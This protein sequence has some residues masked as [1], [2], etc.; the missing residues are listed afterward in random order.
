LTAVTIARRRDVE[1]AGGAI[2]SY[3]RR[4]VG[5]P[6]PQIEVA[7]AAQDGP[8]REE[9]L[10]FWRDRVGFSGEAAERRLG[11]VVC[12]LRDEGRVAGVSSVYAANVEVLAGWRFWI[13]RCLLAEGLDDSLSGLISATFNAL[14]GVH[15]TD[16]G[17]PVGLCVLLDPAQRRHVSPAAEWSDPRMIS[18]GYLPDGRQ[19]RIAYF[20]NEVSSMH[21][22]EPA[23]GWLP[24]GY[25]ME[26]FG[27]ESSVRREDVIALWTSEAGLSRA[28]ADRRL[29]E[30]LL[31]AVAPDGSLA[32]IS[33]AY[34][35]FNAQLGAD[36]WYYRTFVAAAHRKANLAVALIVASR[37]HIVERF[38]SGQDRRGL[39]LIFELENEGLK[40][41]FPK[42]IWYESDFL[43][44]GHNPRGAHVRV[45]YFPG[46]LAP[47]PGLQGS[48]YV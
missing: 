8:L 4:L 12:V 21:I 39:G 24:S 47:E 38:T 15:T 44:I 19:I 33:T 20:S 2:E 34:L 36:F 13:F 45:H 35:T 42:G 11:E 1:T 7:Q 16:R 26:A 5:D 48:T 31:V 10:E 14:D 30:L 27:E 17:E 28:E 6:G 3:H 40:R 41:A 37:D 18:A 23:G 32:G 9:V 29:D 43:F 25:R 22:A 46:V